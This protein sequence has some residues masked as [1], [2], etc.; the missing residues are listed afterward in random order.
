MRILSFFTISILVLLDQISK[1]YAQ[2]NFVVPYQII[3]PWFR[4]RFVENHG[5][6]FSM[7]VPSP[8]VIILTVI[9][10]IYL[11]L[12]LSGKHIV[13]KNQNSKKERQSIALEY[14]RLKKYEIMAI[15]LVFAGA[16]GNLIDRIQFGAVT[17][18]IAV[19]SF[20]VFNLADTWISVGVGI[21]LIGEM[22]GKKQTQ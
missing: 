1:V 5:V 4:F 18:F 21:Y 11:T 3:N 20:P 9:V 2:S 17:D 10:L 13:L 7:P 6:A 15:V 22:F 14:I 16:L 8:F 19:G 12:L